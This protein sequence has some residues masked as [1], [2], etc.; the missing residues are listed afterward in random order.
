M[1]H[2]LKEDNVGPGDLVKDKPGLDRGVWDAS[3]PPMLMR[4]PKLYLSSAI[5]ESLW[6]EGIGRNG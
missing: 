3:K 4:A 2:Q 5:E 1:L 6:V